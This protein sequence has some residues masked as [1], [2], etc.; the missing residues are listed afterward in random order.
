MR[1]LFLCLAICTLFIHV[2]NAY[3]QDGFA[4]NS[5]EIL[6]MLLDSN[7]DGQ[8]SPGRVYLKVEFDVNSAKIKEGAL[9]LVRYL[10]EAMKSPRGKNMQVLLRGHTDSDGSRKAN[11]VLSLHR[12]EAV[13]DYLV[14]EGGISADRIKVEGC[15]EDEPLVPNTSAASKAV[16]RRVEVVNKTPVSTDA[17]FGSETADPAHKGSIGKDFQF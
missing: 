12:A 13:K 7:G 6:D 8:N 4:Y 11:L 2:G 17:L 3:S 5:Q 9:P 15:G 10:A 16:N 14:D 1:K